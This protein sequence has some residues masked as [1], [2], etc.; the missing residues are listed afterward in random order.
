MF[1]TG[2]TATEKGPEP[3]AIG[4]VAFAVV[5]L[6][7]WVVRP[8]V[9]RRS[10][11][12]VAFLIERLYGIGDNSLVGALQFERLQAGAAADDVQRSFV[13]ETERLGRGALGSIRTN[14]LVEGG[15]LL[16]WAGGFAWA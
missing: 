15:R 9:R 6:V 16:A 7:A 8:F 4:V 14:D 10:A 5:S 13:A 11:E 12:S 3:T 2:F 1:V